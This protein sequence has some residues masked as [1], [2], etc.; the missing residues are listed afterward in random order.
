MQQNTTLAQDLSN[1]SKVERLGCAC[2]RLLANKPILAWLLKAIVPEFGA[3][4]VQTVMEKYL[5]GTPA[6]RS[7][8]VGRRHRV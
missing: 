1:Y 4:S 6:I 3:C 7:I 8:P 5:E 2:C